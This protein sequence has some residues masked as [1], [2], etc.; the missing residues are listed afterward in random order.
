[1]SR[2]R[3]SLPRTAVDAP[4]TSPADDPANASAAAQ[5]DPTSAASASPS[6]LLSIECCDDR[7]NSPCARGLVCLG[8]GHAQPKKSAAPVFRRMLVSHQR[9]LTAARSGGEPAGQIAA[10]ELEV[11]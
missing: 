11:I 10:R 2:R 5:P 7:L 1:S 9:S 4:C 3:Q 6:Q 8:C